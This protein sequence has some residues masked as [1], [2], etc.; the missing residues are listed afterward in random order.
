MTCVMYNKKK[1]VRRSVQKATVNVGD[2]E[3]RSLISQISDGWLATQHTNILERVKT[4]N[5][6]TWYETRTIGF[7]L[8]INKY[9]REITCN[10]QTASTT[11]LRSV[12]SV[13]LLVVHYMAVGTWPLRLCLHYVWEKKPVVKLWFK[14][15]RY[16]I[17]EN[18]Y[19]HKFESISNGFSR[20]DS[21]RF[22]YQVMSS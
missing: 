11:W 15:K 16:Q 5:Q 1:L 4:S 14:S 7:H 12:K 22:F 20:E 18:W 21:G 6:V 9:T 8:K 2:P 13:S 3:A 17:L 19:T 10:T